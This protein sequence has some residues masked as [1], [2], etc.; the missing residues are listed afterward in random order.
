MFILRVDK[1]NSCIVNG[2]KEGIDMAN[3]KLVY[4]VSLSSNA[5]Y[6]LRK[7]IKN[8][9]QQSEVAIFFDLDGARVLDKRYLKIME[10][11]HNIDLA[12]S[13]QKALDLGI[14]LFGCQMNVLIADGLDLVEG[15]ELSGVAT[16]L[17]TAYSAD[18]VLSY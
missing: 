2:P 17:D 16:F 15:A 1:I 6:V 4:F 3:K 10:R 9:E 13:M 14:K 18:A 5:P 8:A 11:T 12:Q 7:A